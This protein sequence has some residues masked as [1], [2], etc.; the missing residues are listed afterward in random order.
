MAHTGW[1]ARFECAHDRPAQRRS[2]GRR[3]VHHLPTLHSTRHCAPETLQ[4]SWPAARARTAFR[5]RAS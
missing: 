2:S 4:A 3:L 5:E 1:G